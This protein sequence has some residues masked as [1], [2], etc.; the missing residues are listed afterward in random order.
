MRE[1]L[2]Q[3]NEALNR[4]CPALGNRKLL[5]FRMAMQEHTLQKTP[6]IRCGVPIQ[7][8]VDVEDQAS[9]IISSPTGPR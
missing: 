2:D 1:E 4:I 9:Y 7:Q 5:F 6:Q 3:V 8:K